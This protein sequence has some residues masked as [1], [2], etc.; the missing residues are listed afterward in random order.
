L[1]SLET[2][3]GGPCYRDILLDAPTARS[4]SPDHHAIALDGN[5]TS[6]DDDFRVVGRI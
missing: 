1:K 3:K 2:R 4:D 6:E 5:S